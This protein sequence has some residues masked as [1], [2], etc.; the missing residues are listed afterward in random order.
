MAVTGVGEPTIA[1]EP[2]LLLTTTVSMRLKAGS[3]F[4]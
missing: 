3:N 4:A 1:R 2:V